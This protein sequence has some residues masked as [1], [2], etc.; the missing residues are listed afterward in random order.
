MIILV[1]FLPSVTSNYGDRGSIYPRTALMLIATMLQ[2]AGFEVTLIDGGYHLDYL[3]RLEDA[4]KRH[5]IKVCYVGMSVMT[6]QVPLAL[7]AAQRVKQISPTTPVVWGGVHPSLF[8]EQTL[9]SQ[10]LDIVVINEGAV[11]AVSLAQTM[12]ADG[13]LSGVRGIGYKEPAGEMVFTDPALPED[14]NDLPFLNFELIEIDNYLSQE[15][16]SVYQREFPAFQGK[17]KVLPLLTGLGCPFKCQFCINCILKRHYRYRDAQSIFAEIKRLMAAYD[18]NSFLFLDEDF[19]VNKKRAF[20]LLELVEKEG[21]RFNWR[22]WCRVDHF[23]EDYIN[24]AF[25]KRLLNIGEVSFVMGAESGNQRILDKLDK[26][27]TIQQTL[28]SLCT[29]SQFKAMARYSFIVANEDETM[30]EIRNTLRFC[31]KLKKMGKYVDIA[32]FAFRL[33]PGSPIFD[34]LTAS[35]NIKT[36]N[37]LED[38]EEFI[39]KEEVYTELSWAPANF[40]KHCKAIQFYASWAFGYFG[41][42]KNFKDILK[43][44]LVKTA[45]LRFRFFLFSFTFECYLLKMLRG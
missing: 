20:N 26:G 17:V 4:L 31:T 39:V 30:A 40:Q 45:R 11:T 10:D 15:H 38:W 13:P 8:P 24:P 2:H 14:I 36:P 27:I 12:T 28:D 41:P 42:V 5:K 37:K 22:F 21:L 19:F 3:D 44:I 43:I 32:P 6:T 18:V 16:Q 9:A 25:V 33:Y 35:Y 1:N 7:R 23:K 29:L 34:R